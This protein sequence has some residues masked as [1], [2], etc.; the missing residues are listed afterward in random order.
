MTHAKEV[1][2]LTCG[3]KESQNDRYGK[4]VLMSLTGIYIY[5]I[6]RTSVGGINIVMAS[7]QPFNG[8]TMEYHLE[9]L[10]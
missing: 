9:P 5:R 1:N 6:D 3:R 8:S 4:L 7:N 10:R 2:C